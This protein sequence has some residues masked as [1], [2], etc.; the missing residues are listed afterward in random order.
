MAIFERHSGEHL[1][2]QI[3]TFDPGEIAKH[4]R[5]VEDGVDGWR[6]VNDPRVLDVDPDDEEDPDEL[7]D[8]PDGDGDPVD[9]RPAVRA[10]KEEWVE[11]AV[12]QGLERDEAEAMN[13]ADLIK[14]LKD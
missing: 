9:G 13:K 11:F 8:D 6:E 2:A 1:A 4:R 12:T 3:S 14:A 7:D 5:L 10:P